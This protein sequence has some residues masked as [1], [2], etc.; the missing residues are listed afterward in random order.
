MDAYLSVNR[1][2]NGVSGAEPYPWTDPPKVIDTS[3]VKVPGLLSAEC[4]VNEHG[5]YLAVTL[6]PTPGG[7]RAND[8][9]GDVRVRGEIL[10]DWGLHLIDANLNMG[11]L[12]GI[13]AVETKAYLAK[14]K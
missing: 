2:S 5:S 6:H 3:F 4:V 14:R 1:I 13:V 8:I 10:E 7:A 9:S 12:I 11:N